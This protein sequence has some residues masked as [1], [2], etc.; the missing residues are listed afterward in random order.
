MSDY[1]PGD[2]LV[3]HGRGSRGSESVRGDRFAV[4]M[5][6]H[7][8]RS[9]QAAGR[10]DTY[11]LT[12]N[13]CVSP[14]ISQF[15]PAQ[16]E[17]VGEL[18]AIYS[19]IWQF[20]LSW[21]SPWTG[22]SQHREA[23]QSQLYFAWRTELSAWMTRIW[24]GDIGNRIPLSCFVDA[25][26]MFECVKF[27]LQTRGGRLPGIEWLSETQW[28]WRFCVYPED[29]W[30]NR[31]ESLV[32]PTTTV[33]PP[34]LEVRR[35]LGLVSFKEPPD[36][37]SVE[38]PVQL[39][40]LFAKGTRTEVEPLHASVISQIRTE[41]NHTDWPRTTRFLSIYRQV[42]RFSPL[43][44]YVALYGHPLGIF[45]ERVMPDTQSEDHYVAYSPITS[46]PS[47]QMVRIWVGM[48]YR[49][50][51]LNCLV[52]PEQAIKIVESFLWQALQQPP[53]VSWQPESGSWQ[54]RISPEDDIFDPLE[55]L[56]RR[57]TQ[58]PVPSQELYERLEANYTAVGLPTAAI[59]SL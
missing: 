50:V 9:M 45:I 27:F 15:E 47:E 56:T 20:A 7:E 55:P 3:L 59:R 12:L 41:L 40:V 19:P 17:L 33:S 11:N 1:R 22:D 54:F 4:D 44:G 18:F 32:R 6:F 25:D 26:T 34:E 29:E 48:H 24:L 30:P 21:K 46:Q 8:L 23:N 57:A 43:L 58:S 10:V 38:M 2:L 49:R 16:F 28:P 37:D 5:A 31:H 51:P 35:Q 13:R 36:I 53:S 42:S 39:G 52:P 14:Y